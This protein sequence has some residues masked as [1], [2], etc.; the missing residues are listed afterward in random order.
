MQNNY[1]TS[2]LNNAI[3]V[4]VQSCVASQEVFQTAVDLMYHIYT[5]PIHTRWNNYTEKYEQFS[6]GH[7]VHLWTFADYLNQ[8]LSIDYCG[9]RSLIKGSPNWLILPSDYDYH[10]RD[11][12]YDDSTE[13]DYADISESD[14]TEN[15]IYEFAMPASDDEIIVED[16]DYNN[17]LFFDPSTCTHAYDNDNN[18]VDVDADDSKVGAIPSADLDAFVV[19][20]DTS[21]W[22]SLLDSP[23]AGTIPKYDAQHKPKRKNTNK[24]SEQSVPDSGSPG[25]T[26]SGY[27]ISKDPSVSYN[28]CQN[29]FI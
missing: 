10:Q 8:M 15:T 2:Y 29:F 25:S 21:D 7:E 17:E 18:T 14:Y 27:T 11:A 23:G 20:D 5:F 16:F 3:D 24:S 26:S 6:I 22:I 12:D 4:I 28:D 9:M 19:D 13:Y 1:N